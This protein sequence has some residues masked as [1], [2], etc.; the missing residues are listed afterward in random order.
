V[1]IP[2]YVAEALRSTPHKNPKYFFWTGKSKVTT[3]RIAEVFKLAKVENGHP[4]RFRDTFA[5]SLLD[6]GVSLENVSTLL[7]HQSVRV[8]ENT[9]L[10][11]SKPGRTPSM[12]LSKALSQPKIIVQFWYNYS[13]HQEKSQFVQ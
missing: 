7:G 4:H 2:P 11:G 5:V 3:A 9:I 13:G 8:S 10:R 6:A 12:R 1:L